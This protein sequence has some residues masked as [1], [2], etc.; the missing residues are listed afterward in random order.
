M[1]AMDLGVELGARTYVFWGGREGAEVD[2]AKDPIEAIAIS[3]GDRFPVRIRARSA[4][5]AALCAGGQAERATGRHLLPTTASY[6][7]FIETLAYSRWASIPKS[8]TSTCW[9]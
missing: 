4:L 2:A 6:L 5:L 9:G 1:R 8:R 7:A 3:R